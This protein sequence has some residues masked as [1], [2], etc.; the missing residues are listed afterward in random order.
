MRMHMYMHIC[1]WSART[2]MC[3][4]GWVCTWVGFCA[5]VRFERVMRAADVV[6][7]NAYSMRM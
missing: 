7:I 1:M 4:G 6:V 3:V 5:Q 2:C